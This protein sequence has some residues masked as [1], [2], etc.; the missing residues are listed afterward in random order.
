MKIHTFTIIDIASGKVLKDEWEEYEGPISRCD[1]VSALA[2]FAGTEILGGISGYSQAQAA[3]HAA[4]EQANAANAATQA[5]LRMFEETRGDLVPWMQQGN[6][7][8][9]DMNKFL[10]LNT[11]P[12]GGMDPNAPGV[13]PFSLADFQASPAYNFNL[14]QGKQAIDK[15]SAARGNF[16]APSTLQDVAKFSQGLA[17]NEFQNA[18]SN[19]N[20]NVGNVYNRLRDVSGSGQNAAARIG[21]FGTSVG[22]QVGENMIGAGNAAAAGRIGAANA[23]TGGLQNL[24]N[25]YNMYQMMQRPSVTPDSGVPPIGGAGGVTYDPGLNNFGMDP[26]NPYF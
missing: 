7:A 14:E 3:K 18:Y 26:T 23:Y 24:Y 2:T 20:T 6:I 12:G 15:A 21:A 9:S 13:K 16:Y 25:N 10:G 22:A 11:G 4:D 19:Y 5:Q 1:P 17:S 8:M